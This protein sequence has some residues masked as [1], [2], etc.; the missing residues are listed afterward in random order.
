MKIETEISQP[1]VVLCAG[2]E[3]RKIPG[4]VSAF[5]GTNGKILFVKSDGSILLPSEFEWKTTKGTYK[6]IKIVSD[7]F[8]QVTKA[9]HQLVCQ[10]YSGDPPKDGYIYEPN[11]LN[12][13]KHDNRPCNLEWTTRAKNIQHAY[14]SGLCTQGLRIDVTDVFSKEV[15][16]FHSLS[17]LARHM[18][19]PR[20]QL[21]EIVAKHR[22]QPYLG[23]YTFILDESSD[24]KINRHQS[25]EI[26]Y[27]DYVTGE[28]TIVKTAQDASARTGVKSGT[29]SLRTRQPLKKDA[30]ANLLSRYLF[31]AY[32]G[33]VQWPD[34]PKWLAIESEKKYF[35]KYSSTTS[36]E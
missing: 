27:K 8:I 36:K 6:Y 32:A 33:Q 22:S 19:I 34:I 13:N 24:R 9:V 18:G 20:H 25:K 35:Q 15:K 5:A 7:D 11:H 2:L 29:I 17:S 30:A 4:F 14:D 12:G 21:R 26:I 10:V 3:Y 28:V 1:E 31:L 23:Q 16:T